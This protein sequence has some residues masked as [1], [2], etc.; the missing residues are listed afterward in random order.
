M[1]IIITMKIGEEI[2]T[3]KQN[4]YGQAIIHG[5]DLDY[6]A[7][8]EKVNKRKLPP[9]ENQ[10]NYTLKFLKQYKITVHKSELP[11]FNSVA[12]MESWRKKQIMI[13]LGC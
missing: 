5:D 2:M 11:L 8:Q 1:Q 4:S 9:T 6:I 12:E 7:V 3:Y 13:R 10:L